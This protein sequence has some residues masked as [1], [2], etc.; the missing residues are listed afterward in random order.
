MTDD[1]LV[2]KTI[3]AV[4]EADG[5][6]LLCFTDGSG[7]LAYQAGDDLDSLVGLARHDAREVRAFKARIAGKREAA[8]V[9]ALARAGWLALSCEERAAK[10]RSPKG[11]LILPDWFEDSFIESMFLRP[12][13]T[14]R[15]RCERCGERECPN[16]AVVVV[17]RSGGVTTNAGSVTISRQLLEGS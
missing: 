17:Q 1:E 15:R 7:L 12:G 11:V 6:A 10:R 13:S 8:R 16:A 5:E 14:H 9:E 2:G 4:I 3:A